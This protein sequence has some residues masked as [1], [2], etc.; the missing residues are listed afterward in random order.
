MNKKVSDKAMQLTYSLGM[1]AL[2]IICII[3]FLY[4]VQKIFIQN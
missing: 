4:L 2:I 1:L 3:G